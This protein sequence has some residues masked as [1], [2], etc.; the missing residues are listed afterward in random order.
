VEQSAKFASRKRHLIAGN[1][2]MNGLLEDARQFIDAL[3]DNPAPDH[4]EVALMP[5]FTLLHPMAEPL[6]QKDVRLGAQSVYFE[7]SGAFTGS[8][9]AMMLRDVGCHYVILGHSERRDIIGESDNIIHSKL[10]AAWN[11]GLEPILCIGEHLE[12]RK[13]GK[14]NAVLAEQLSVLEAAS[15]DAPLTVAYEPVWAIGT[16]LTATPEQVTE[17]HAFIHSELARMGH[18]CRVLYGGSVKPDNTAAL[19]ACPGVEGALVGGASLQAESFNQ[20]I[21]AAASV[22]TGE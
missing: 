17:T 13:T 2:K 1:W 4:V 8:V 15:A 14:T 5:P 20:I 19:M 6:R 10:D 3:D 12:E 11:A 7:K 18:D 9:S 22:A 21:Q 16:G